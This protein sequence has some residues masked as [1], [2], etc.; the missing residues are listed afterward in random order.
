MKDKALISQLKGLRQIEPSKDWVVSVR[1]QIVG[2]QEKVSFLNVFPVLFTAKKLAYA[3][4]TLVLFVLGTLGFAQNTVPGDFLFPVK[5]ISQAALLTGGQTKNNLDIAS[6]RLDDLAMVVKDNRTANLAPAMQELKDS[7]GE[8]VK[9]LSEDIKNDPESLRS[10]AMQVKQIEDKKNNLETL[11][12]VMQNNEMAGLNNALIIL[13]QGEIK[14]LDRA[15][16]TDDQ[17]QTLQEIKD[18]YFKA[19]YSGALEKVLMMGS[20]NQ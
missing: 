10:V 2:E 18:L 20:E 4:L 13:L 17:Q 11:G 9:S 19:D 3:S 12:V 1:R 8:A 7:I 15:N 16:L 14:S 6:K 5:K